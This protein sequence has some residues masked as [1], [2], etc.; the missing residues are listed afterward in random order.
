VSI[1]DADF[2]GIYHEQDVKDYF[3][4]SIKENDLYKALH[5]DQSTKRPIFNWSCR[6][7]ARALDH[8]DLDDWTHWYDLVAGPKNVSILINAGVFDTLDGPQT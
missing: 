4:N 8:E 3:M 6:E 5:M 7:C 1:N 2:E